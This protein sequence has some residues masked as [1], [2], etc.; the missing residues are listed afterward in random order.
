M[1]SKNSFLL[2]LLLGT[3]TFA[4][5]CGGG[6]GDAVDAAP[7]FDADLSPDASEGLTGLGEACDGEADPTTCTNPTPICAYTDLPADGQCTLICAMTA[8]AATMAPTESHAMCEAAYSGPEGSGTPFCGAT[9]AP[10]GGM[11]P[12]GCVILCGQLQG[13]PLGDCIAPMTCV[14]QSGQTYGTCEY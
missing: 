8:E 3:L 11:K 9:F 7:S 1:R 4:P 12:W 5:A 2:A 14:L 13:N 6:D 10:S